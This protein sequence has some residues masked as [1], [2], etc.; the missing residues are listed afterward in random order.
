MMR[1]TAALL[2]ALALGGCA[3]SP[4]VPPAQRDMPLSSSWTL[5]GRIGI[6][7]D[8]QSLSGQIHWQHRA[9][10]D[11]V[12]MTS[13][14]GQGVARIERNAAG[15][16][17]EV[18]NQPARHAPDAELLTR[19]ALGYGLPV[20]GLMWWVQAR[21]S[22]ES[23]FMVTQD[24]DGRIGQLKQDGWVIDYLQYST[25]APWRPRKLVVTREGLEI[26]LVVDDWQ[27][28]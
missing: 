10:S 19:E 26:R 15:V 17:L 20:S 3:S 14:L 18:P 23:P 11:E 9:D 24:A 1:P 5:Q 27:N 2:L 13:P 25:D 22:P 7:T 6:K 21:P 16:T 4:P 8:E 28:E 12:L